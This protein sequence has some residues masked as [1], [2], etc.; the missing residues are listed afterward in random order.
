MP[1]RPKHDQ[2]AVCLQRSE[3]PEHPRAEKRGSRTRVGHV[4]VMIRSRVLAPSSSP[5]TVALQPR[6]SPLHCT[7]AVPS[8]PGT[9]TP[10]WPLCSPATS[11]PPPHGR[12]D[13]AADSRP[14][15]DPSTD[16]PD[17][18]GRALL[19]PPRPRP[20]PA[21]TE[22]Q[23][24]VVTGGSAG[25]GF[26]IVAHLLQHNAAKIYLLSNK[27][28]HAVRA[29]EALKEWGDASRVEWKKCDLEDLGQV[30][31]VAKELSRLDRID[32][33]SRV[34]PRGGRVGRSWVWLTGAAACLQRRPRRRRLQRDQ[35]RHR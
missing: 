13:P 20:R 31:E 5:S 3:P 29:R 14:R 34:L 1:A 33:V 21:L 30:D 2:G 17:L 25:I 9:K 19:P 11:T 15:F 8:T 7:C 26:G 12:Q 28:E 6:Q 4:C 35:G 27:E 10:T 24:Y 18:T 32:G 22:L 16:V 23:T